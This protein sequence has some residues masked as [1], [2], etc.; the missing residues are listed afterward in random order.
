[1]TTAEKNRIIKKALVQAGYKN[2]SV[3]GSRGTAYGWVNIKVDSRDAKTR[4]EAW[5][6]SGKVREIA[7]NA[8][9]EVGERFYTYV[10]DD[11]YNTE[12]ECVHVDVYISE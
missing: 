8:L 1:M 4:D 2:V 12:S 9:S 11:G 6:E 10:S 5:K 7:R 3:T